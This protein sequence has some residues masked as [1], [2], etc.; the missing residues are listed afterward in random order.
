MSKDLKRLL[1]NRALNADKIITPRLDAWLVTNDGIVL[2][3]DLANDMVTL[4][5]GPGGGDRTNAF[6]ASSSDLCLRRQMFTFLDLPGAKKMY[7]SSL[8]NK[9]NNGHWV[10]MRWQAM[11]MTAGIL[12]EIEVKVE[13]PEFR[14]VGHMDG[15]GTDDKG[16]FGF[17]L[18]GW[19]ALVDQPKD[20]HIRQIQSYMMAS[21][22]DRF[23]LIY[24]HKSSQDWREF[25]VKRDE[26]IIAEIVD[27][28]SQLNARY[29]AGLFPDMLSMCKR[30]RGDVFKTCPYR[31]VCVDAKEWSWLNPE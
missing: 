4:M 24:E 26:G 17:E 21:G 22:L 31:D 7:D 14:F 23:S 5:T 11:L 25:I 13:V 12:D 3:P 8:Q 10:H 30:E 29:E 27:D 6:H 1:K 28:L 9:F 20:Y 2:T 15:I 18:K 16:R 19:S